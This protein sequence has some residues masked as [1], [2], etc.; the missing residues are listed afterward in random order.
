MVAAVKLAVLIALATLV[1]VA[2][3]RAH[4]SA[5]GTAPPGLTTYGQTMWNLDALLHD[6]FGDKDVYVNSTDSYP[7]SP[8]NF[9]TAF[10]NNAHSRYY[11]YTFANA[12]HSS[13]RLFGPTKP[14]SPIIGASGYEVP[15]KIN[16]SFIYCGTGKWLFEHGGNGPANWAVSCHTQRLG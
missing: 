5:G 14:P 7:R 1:S 3:A 6:T 15:L 11:I 2:G 4:A 9:S 16:G 13:F 8:A 12:H 10:I